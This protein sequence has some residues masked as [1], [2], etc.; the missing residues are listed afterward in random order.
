MVTIF[1]IICG[2][3]TLISLWLQISGLLPQYRTYFSHAAAGFLGLTIGLS[4]N[5]GSQLNLR[6]PESLTPKQLVGVILFGG[7]GLLSAALILLSVLLRNEKQRKAASHAASAVSTFLIFA[8][9]FFLHSFF[10][11]G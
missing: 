2:I 6:L 10:P 9:M 3:A 4:V 1:T 5:I 11:I 7:S 8:L